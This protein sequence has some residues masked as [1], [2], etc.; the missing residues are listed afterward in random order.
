MENNKKCS[1]IL[2]NSLNNYNVKNKMNIITKLFKIDRSTF[3]RWY[4]EYNLNVTNYKNFYNFNFLNVTHVIVD[5]IVSYANNNI[6]VSLKKIKKN[7]N[8]IIPNNNLSF[9]Q[10]NVII[11]KN[12][13]MTQYHKRGNYKIKSK[14][15]K[16]I[17]E[18]IKLKNTLTAKDII[19][20]IKDK[21]NVDVSLTSVYNI[22]KK[23]NY[24]YK[25]TSI[26]INPH[27]FHD[28]K[29]QLE[30]VYHYLE[31]NI[32]MTTSFNEQ[33]QTNINKM[34][35]LIKN[36]MALLLDKNI[37]FDKNYFINLNELF[38]KVSELNENSHIE[39]NENSHIELNE[40]SHIELNENSHIELNE[41]SHI[42]LVSIDEFSIITNRASTNGWSLCGEECIIKLPYLKQN[43]RYSLLMATT[44]KKIIKYILKEGSIKSSDFILFID[45]L[46]KLNKNYSYLIDNA[47]IH[48]NKKAKEF[49]K[50]NKINIIFNAPYQSKFNPIEMVFSL[51]RKKLN[52]RI[53]K[54]QKEIEEE[55]EQFIKEIKEET[56]KNIFN[57]S[58]KILKLY[59]EINTIKI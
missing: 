50:T 56:L 22:F 32:Q 27:S 29:Q 58:T 26:N 37:I 8:K 33:Y 53:V 14:I 54:A 17:V 31:N 20:S 19:K 47:S 9:K 39:L 30:N 16:F 42:E 44:N 25:K 35:E 48:T 40:N 5:Y 55:I 43:K 18:Q 10:I 57:H 41:N 36:D 13:C 3:Y 34:N 1:V 7:I 38:K 59:L 15:E 12:N 6:I 24:T 28:Q 23:N 45:D 46:N 2:Y 21:F 11:Q 4:N 49:Y 51:L 52:K